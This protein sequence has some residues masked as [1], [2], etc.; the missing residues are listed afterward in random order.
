[1]MPYMLLFF[2]LLFVWLEFYL[3]GGALAIGGAILLFAAVVTFVLQS[4]SVLSSLLFFI[5]AAAATILVIRFA[6]LGLKKSA[7]KNTFFLSRDQEGYKA[8][9][10]QASLLGKKGITLTEFGP[11]GYV[12][13]DGARHAAICRGPY[14]EKGCEVIVIAG[15]S[16]H[17]I[18]KP[19]KSIG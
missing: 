13:I 11:S 7:K 15:E 12:L 19:C 5:G 8:A 18:V 2:G 9:E 10:F 6:I 16:G 4:E 14:L 17:L 1:M 3:P